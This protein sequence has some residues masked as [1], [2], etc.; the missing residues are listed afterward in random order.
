[1]RI[2][3]LRLGL[4]SA[5]LLLLVG[6]PAHAGG[7]KLA[8]KV[9][10]AQNQSAKVDKRLEGLVKQLD[11]LKFKGYEL[12]DEATFE[13]ELG[14]SGRMQ[15][16]SDKTPARREDVAWMTVT[17]LSLAPDGKLKL[18]LE[19]KDLKFKTTVV[20]AQGATLA[21]GGPAYDGGAII[22]AVTRLGT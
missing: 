18:E 7:Y 3:N 12:K 1:M 22:L 6:A 10:H 13:L 20:L 17:P 8:V 14:A 11:A 15:V 19:V 9:V 4:A 21:V 2:T 5:L 16:P